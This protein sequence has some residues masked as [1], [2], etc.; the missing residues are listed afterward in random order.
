M[1]DII[2]KPSRYA[3]AAAWHRIDA[4]DRRTRQAQSTMEIMRIRDRE[5]EVRLWGSTSSSSDE[6]PEDSENEAETREGEP[7]VPGQSTLLDTSREA[8]IMARMMNPIET[9]TPLVKT[10]LTQLRTSQTDPGEVQW[11]AEHTTHFLRMLMLLDPGL[12]RFKVKEDKRKTEV[13]DHILRL[14]SFNTIMT[15]NGR[16]IGEVFVIFDSASPAN[17]IG[18]EMVNTLG[19]EVT[20]DEGR[21]KPNFA[22]RNPLFIEGTTDVEISV[23]GKKKKATLLVSKEVASTK[24]IT[25]SWHLMEA[26]GL[27]NRSAY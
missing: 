21:A 4:R 1:S 8:G 15:Q 6:A 2:R 11:T 14:P 7:R 19:L 9:N 25:I 26:W 3:L 12:D 27:L 17:M 5:R 24:H 22:G 10:Y 23:K 18:Q 16:T 13:R 20:M